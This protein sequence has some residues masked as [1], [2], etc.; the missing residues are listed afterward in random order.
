[1]C[2]CPSHYA[3]GDLVL[4]DKSNDA[5]TSIQCILE[6]INQL[7]RHPIEAVTMFY[8]RKKQMKDMEKGLPITDREKVKCYTKAF[9]NHLKGNRETLIKEGEKAKR[10]NK[11]EKSQ[12]I[13]DSPGGKDPLEVLATLPKELKRA[14]E[15]NDNKDM[16]EILSNK[17][18]KY[19]KHIK[20]ML[21][22]GLLEAVN[23]DI[24]FSGSESGDELYNQN[25]GKNSKG[26]SLSQVKSMTLTD[27]TSEC[28]NIPVPYASYIDEID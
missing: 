15:S 20:A 23:R 7:K 3:K 25:C 26:I 9:K 5:K 16:A 6:L 14:Y 11:R 8:N 21:K 2:T 24:N 10:K 17:D 18:G 27:D 22:A 12:R 28:F 4:A 13:K 1:M 19:D